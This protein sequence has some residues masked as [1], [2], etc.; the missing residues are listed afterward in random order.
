VHTHSGRRYLRWLAVTALL[1]IVAALATIVVVDPYGLYDVANA[2]GFNRVKPRPARYQNEIKLTRASRVR[3]DALILGNSRAEIGF[4]PEARAF[5]RAGMS[6]YNLA[7]P[8]STISTARRQLA[9]LDRVDAAP[10]AVL[11]GLDF[12]DFVG[13]SS[14]TDARTAQHP[15]EGRDHPVERLGWRV[16][17]LF[18]LTSLNDALR[19]LRVQ[20]DP[21][22]EVTT[23]RG[24]N[25]LNEYRPLA[26][27]EGYYALFRQRAQENARSYV[28]LTDRRLIPE[29]FAELR[30]MLDTAALRGIEVTLVIYP[31]HAQILAMLEEVGLS[32]MFDEWKRHITE[33]VAAASERRPSARTVLADLSGY[34]VYQCEAIP[35]RDDRSTETRWYWEAGHFK[36]EL[37]DVMLS[38]MLAPPESSVNDESFGSPLQPDKIDAWLA[39]QRDLADRHAATVEASEASRYLCCKSGNRTATA[40]Q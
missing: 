15:T 33:E 9:Y 34:G 5:S 25:P 1:G 28:R 22:A 14:P 7:I 31:Y 4:D 39:H 8:G 32:V 2:A 19:T 18:S 27:R 26:R 13:T 20:H 24:F 12:L 23:S 16:D 3:A 35:M 30:A 10:K 37:G 6:A 17:S 29:R 21:D 36:K 11:I 38:M 40:H